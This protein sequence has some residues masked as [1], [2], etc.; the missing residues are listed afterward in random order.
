MTNEVTSLV[1]IAV[2]LGLVFVIGMVP[3]M[4]NKLDLEGWAVGGR[5]FGRWLNWF[6]LAGEIYTAFAFLGASGWAYAKGGP[7]FYI[8]G[9]GG[10]AYVVG[11]HVLPKICEVGHA[12][13]LLTQ[14]DLIAHLYKSE[15]LAFGTALVGV[16][17]LLPY[18]QLQ[19]TGLGLIIET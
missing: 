13:K 6:V 15:K 1:V 12:N 2:M 10:L 19:L 7:I 5:S 17:F 18:L 16:A 3:G 9:Y 11:Y 8:L 4:K 14:P